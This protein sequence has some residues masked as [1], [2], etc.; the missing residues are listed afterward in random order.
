MLNHLIKKIINSCSSHVISVMSWLRTQVI[1]FYP[2]VKTIWKSFLPPSLTPSH[3]QGNNEFC[4]QS[5]G[6]RV[7]CVFYRSGSWL[8]CLPSLQAV[9]FV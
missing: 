2:T 9:P 4:T 8:T 1:V 7:L 3:E 6:V 5:R